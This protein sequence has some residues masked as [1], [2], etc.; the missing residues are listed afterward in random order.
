MHYLST[1]CC[2]PCSFPS[3][4]QL[5]YPEMNKRADEDPLIPEIRT[6]GDVTSCEENDPACPSVKWGDC[7]LRPESWLNPPGTTGS[8]LGRCGKSLGEMVGPAALALRKREIGLSLT[9]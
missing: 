7:H 5:N 6:T 2:F 9:L 4:L 1:I 8:I 3:A